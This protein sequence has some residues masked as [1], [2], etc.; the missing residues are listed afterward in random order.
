MKTR[1]FTA[2]FA[3]ACL[4]MVGCSEE[5]PTQEGGTPLEDPATSAGAFDGHPDP[6]LS[7]PTVGKDYLDSDRTVTMTALPSMSEL[8]QA[9]D[10][11]NV[12]K[13][14]GDFV[15]SEN[16]NFDALDD[17]PRALAAGKALSDV[18][19]HLTIHGHDKTPPKSLVARAAGALR[20]IDPPQNVKS[21][22]DDVLNGVQDGSL[23]GKAAVAA[24]EEIVRD[25]LPDLT[26]QD[27]FR[28][29]AHA[30][31]FGA[32]LRG[33]SVAARGMLENDDLGQQQYQFLC[34]AAVADFFVN[35]FENEAGDKWKNAP[36]ILAAVE[37][38]K[39]ALPIMSKCKPVE[40]PVLTK[41]DAS[42]IARI[43]TAYAD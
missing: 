10:S 24:V 7:M 29:P 16:P 6:S 4:G 5:T 34:Q 22:A 8:Y 37:A 23:Q 20:A 14:W 40:T 31:L 42:E 9:A 2:L 26:G 21:D 18:G 33:S 13:G 17:A 38:T 27:A 30:A 41:A 39:K 32:F 43:F 35:Y 25:T 19:F 12:M 28:D 11:A 15:A 3:I 1:G 36:S